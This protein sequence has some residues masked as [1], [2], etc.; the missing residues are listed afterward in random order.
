MLERYTD[1]DK[2]AWFYDRYWGREY[3]QRALPILDHLLLTYLPQRAFILDL[4]CGVGHLTKLLTDRDFRLVGLD[5]SLEMLRHAQQNAPGAAFLVA[6]ARFFKLR[7]Q[8]SAV[9][10]TF[11]SMNHIL[12]L[13]ELTAVF[14]NVYS[15][16]RD[17]GRFLFDVLLEEAYRMQWAKSGCMV[18]DDNV[19][20]IR[21]DYDAEQRIARA[22]ITLFR[23]DGEWRRSDVAI[24]ERCYELGEVWNA[25][26]EVGF[27]EI[28]SYDAS[29]RL[30]MPGDLG[31]G[32]VFFAAK[33]GG[34]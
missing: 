15:A 4:C 11:E 3:P 13:D 7:H 31:V 14:R 30:G 8:F 1:Y 24:H 32:R 26:E 28:N 5:R 29:R 16:L 34:G 23:K 20:I 17:E 6:D 9:I 33:K 22:H 18:E 25:L 10:S 19:C 12:S 27:E 21:G 2:L